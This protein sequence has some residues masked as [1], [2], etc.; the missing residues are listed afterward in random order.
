MDTNNQLSRHT[1]FALLASLAAGLVS[2][3]MITLFI[4]MLTLLFVPC[5][6]IMVFLSAR[7]AF[8]RQM[9]GFNVL[10]GRKIFGIAMEVGSVTHFYTF[11]LY[12]PIAFFIDG[13]SLEDPQIIGTYLFM[14][15]ILG[16]VSLVMFVW[17]AVPL[18]MGVGHLLKSIEGEDYHQRKALDDS[19]LDDGFL[20]SDLDAV[21]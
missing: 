11:A 14:T 18:Y 13:G 4:D 6:M 1:K 16:I 19:L 8:R 12:I 15:F 5:V 2:F 3:L 10:T 7:S 21:S 9:K 17:I 20:S